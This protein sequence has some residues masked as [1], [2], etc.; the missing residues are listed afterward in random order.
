[1][2]F[3]EEFNNIIKN[4]RDLAIQ[5]ESR[6]IFS[7]HFL[8]A[9]KDSKGIAGKI[10]KSNNWDFGPIEEALLRDEAT[11]ILDKYFLLREFENSIKN[12]NFYSW[13]YNQHTVKPEHVLF[14]MLADKDSLAGKHLRSIGVTYSSFKKDYQILKETNTKSFFEILGK[15]IF[16]VTIGFPRFIKK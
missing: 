15:N 14:A 16:F 5:Y 9:L 8:L 12:S 11:E 7:Y 3:N 10:I 1:M 6:F 13:V 2:V 4:S